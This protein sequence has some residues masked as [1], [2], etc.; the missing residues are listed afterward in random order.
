[1]MTVPGVGELPQLK[2]VLSQLGVDSQIPPVSDSF[3][4]KQHGKLADLVKMHR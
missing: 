3:S 1:M 4:Q 2:H